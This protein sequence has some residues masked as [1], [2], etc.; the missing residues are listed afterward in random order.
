V[1]LFP[2]LL[3]LLSA[4]ALSPAG[5]DA[6]EQARAAV[7]AAQSDAQ[8]AQ[9]APAELD[10]AARALRHAEQPSDERAHRAYLAEQRARIARELASARAHDA[11]SVQANRDALEKRAREAEGERDRA[12]ARAV[13]AEEARDVNDR[14]A[15]EVRRLQA[16]V[17]ELE[18]AKTE[19]GWILTLGSDLLF[20]VGKAT[21]KPGGRHALDNLA[22]FM[23]EHEER[24]IAIEGFTDNSGSESLNQRLSERR[25]HAVREALVHG[26]IDAE[27][28]VARGLGA[29]YPVASN[30]NPGGRQLN[31]RVEILIGEGV[32]R[33]ATGA[34]RSAH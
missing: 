4:C 7:R 15:A 8:V 3:L 21:L 33:A 1:R 23:R 25:A 20:D 10:L 6:L 32:G 9:Y 13:A 27:R 29:A 17:A 24:K 11:Q 30:D 14:L 2:L 26:G 31:R 28:I 18:A 22:R 34:S 12:L 19:R 5:N 16:Q